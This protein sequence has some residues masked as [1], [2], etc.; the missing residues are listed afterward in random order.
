MIFTIEFCT[1]FSLVFVFVHA[2]GLV[3]QSH[4]QL[5][6]QAIHSDSSINT[7]TLAAA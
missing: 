5:I 7:G 2:L 6:N 1:Q 4:D 3:G